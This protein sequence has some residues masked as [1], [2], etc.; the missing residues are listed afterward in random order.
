MKLKMKQVISFSLVFCFLIFFSNF[1]FKEQVIAQIQ[2]KLTDAF[3]VFDGNNTRTVDVKSEGDRRGRSG[4][5][6][7]NIFS[8]FFNSREISTII[9]SLNLVPSLGELQDLISYNY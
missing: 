2:K 1:C 3:D 5:I 4:V 7:S 9:Y 8:F 6:A